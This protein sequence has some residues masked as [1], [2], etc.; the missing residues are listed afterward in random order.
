MSFAHVLGVE[1]GR[2]RRRAD[3][4]AEHDRQPSPLGLGGGRQSLRGRS[5]A[6][7]RRAGPQGGDRGEQ[8]AAVADRGDAEADQVVGRQLG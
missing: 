1:A 4:V 7:R 8:L 5:G 6:D 3:E 2:E